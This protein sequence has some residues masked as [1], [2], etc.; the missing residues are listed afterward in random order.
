MMDSRMLCMQLINGYGGHPG[1]WRMA[2]ANRSAFTVDAYVDLARTAEQGKFVD[3]GHGRSIS[4]GRGYWSPSIQ[5][6]RCTC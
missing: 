2:G 5:R 3:V 1:A 6:R 4:A